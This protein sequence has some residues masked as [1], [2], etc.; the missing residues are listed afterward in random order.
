MAKVFGFFLLVLSI[1][2]GLE[3]M[4]HGMSGAFDGLFVRVGLASEA[5]GEPDSVVKRAGG[6]FDRAYRQAE[7]RTARHVD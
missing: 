7:E 5:Q 6:A 1:W 4:N 3:V 2:V